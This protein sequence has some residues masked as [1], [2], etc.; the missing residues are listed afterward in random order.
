MGF[1][2]LDNPNPNTQQW[3]Y[4]R[5]GNRGKLSGTC[6]IHTSESAIDHVGPDAG[7]EGCAGFIARR[8]DYGSYH[9]L[10]DSD[11]IIEMLPYEYEA[12]QDSETNNWAVGLSCAVRAGEWNTIAVPRRDAIYW[13]LATAAADFVTY[14]RTK[15]IEVP[16]VR[17]N[18]AQARNGIPGFCAHGDSGISRSD[19]G[20][21]FEWDRFFKYV[22]AKLEGTE[23]EMAFTLE[24]IAQAVWSFK[25]TN[26]EPERDTYQI[27]RDKAENKL[28]NQYGAVLTLGEQVGHIDKNLNDARVLLL[29]AIGANKTEVTLR[30]E[31]IA[32]L[33]G[34]LKDT[35]GPSLAS[36]LAKRLT[37]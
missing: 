4:P 8:T 3:A 16:R 13:N 6:I 2:L 17:I 35:L 20:V 1:Y 36:E 21:Q 33:A 29:T 23:E 14:M 28:T 9:T 34:S 25:N 11:S 19:P 18:G 37:D 27:L 10:V 5:R 24:E 32:V 15:G 31:D 7:A 12:W 30:P 22:D 26:A